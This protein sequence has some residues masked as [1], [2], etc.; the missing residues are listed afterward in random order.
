MFWSQ[1]YAFIIIFNL[2]PSYSVFEVIHDNMTTI[3]FLEHPVYI[4]AKTKRYGKQYLYNISK[5]NLLEGT[6]K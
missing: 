2:G 3:F 6:N 1:L 5:I 4:Q